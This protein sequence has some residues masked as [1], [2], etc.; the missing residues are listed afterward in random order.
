MA[1][2][3]AGRS[4]CLL[5]GGLKNH[6]REPPY[7]ISRGQLVVQAFEADTFDDFLQVADPDGVEPFTLILFEPGRLQRWVWDGR[8]SHQFTPAPDKVH[9]W[10][11]ATLYTREE[12]A[13][14]E[15][16]FRKALDERGSD[17]EALLGIH[18]RD[19]KTP[20][21]L[22]REGVRTLSITQLVLDGNSLDITY[23][24]FGDNETARITMPVDQHAL[25]NGPANPA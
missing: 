25:G 22:D 1:T 19:T 8:H 20:F 12:H 9:L 24:K 7:R 4:A 5:N 18:G 6:K 3:H 14:K 23:Y 16:Y 17:R 10:S 21:I 2:D 13:V 11:S 15:G